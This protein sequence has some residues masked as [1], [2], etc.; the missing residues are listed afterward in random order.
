M[1]FLFGLSNALE[2]G[3]KYANAIT[4][5][6]LITD[7]QWDVFYSIS[8]CA[9]ID[10]AKKDFNYTQHIKNAYKLFLHI[11]LCIR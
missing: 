2:F 7:T 4:F 1:I 11:A 3:E 9:Q 8:V 6:A 10:I 5:V